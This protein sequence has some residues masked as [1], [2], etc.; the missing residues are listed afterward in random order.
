MNR[1]ITICILLLSLTIACAPTAIIRP[2]TPTATQTSPPPTITQPP[3]ASSVAPTVTPE[4]PRKV[5]LPPPGYLY[6]GVFP[7]GISGEEDDLSLNDLRG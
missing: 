2:V 3:P 6:H 1:R 7:G 5:P 4:P